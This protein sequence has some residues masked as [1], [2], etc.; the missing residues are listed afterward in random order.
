[1]GTHFLTRLNS[2]GVYLQSKTDSGLP[3]PSGRFH[4][5]FVN[6]LTLESPCEGLAKCPQPGSLTIYAQVRR[7][8]V[9]PADD[10]RAAMTELVGTNDRRQ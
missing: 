7:K 1:M 6:A 5:H 3:E 8:P 4:M 2:P 10:I 9:Q